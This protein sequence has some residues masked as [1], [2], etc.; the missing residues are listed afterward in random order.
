MRGAGGHSARLTVFP[1]EHLGSCDY[2][3]FFYCTLFSRE[4]IDFDCFNHGI[5]EGHPSGWI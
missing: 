1:R 2:F 5:Y 4:D 3:V